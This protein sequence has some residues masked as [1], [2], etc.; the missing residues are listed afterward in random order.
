MKPQ[1]DQDVQVAAVSAPELAAW[2][3]EQATDGMT[4]FLAHA[5][6]GVIWGRVEDKQLLLAGSVFP[7]VAV[8]LRPTTLQ[9]ARLFGPAGELFLWRDDD[10]FR[11]RRIMDGEK[12]PDNALPLEKYW[13]WGTQAIGSAG[14]FKLLED[15]AQGLHHAPPISALGEGQRLALLVRHYL[16][17]DAEGRT[18]IAASR[19]YG[20]QIVDA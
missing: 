8:A 12:T 14:G 10:R 9:Q 18:R 20:L 13:L 2:F 3:A 17:Y 4:L 16:A 15:G 11:V 1:L 6:D 7:E 19:L 5:D